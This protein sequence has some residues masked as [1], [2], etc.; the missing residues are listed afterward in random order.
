M[1]LK[2]RVY[3]LL[4][5]SSSDRFTSS[6]TTLLPES[7]YSPVKAV[8]SISAAKRALA[9][10][11]FDLIV[12]NSPLPDGTGSGFA[13]DSA[14]SPSQV[15]L[16]LARADV[17]GDL[18]ALVTEHGVFTL[19]KPVSRQSVER[20]L[21]WM[22]ASRERLRRFEKKTV[23]IDE[24]MAEIRLVSRAKWLLIGELG[25]DE[26]QAHRYIEKQ[27]MDRCVSKRTIAEEIIKT[28]SAQ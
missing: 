20:A 26:P 23:S 25:M 9:E 14:A 16:I 1:S 12:I 10:R 4:V 13:I 6:F 18:S 22:A 15:V 3:S 2:E 7:G 5:V 19:P 21:E 11:P 24:K 28:Y 27:A 17:F 8:S